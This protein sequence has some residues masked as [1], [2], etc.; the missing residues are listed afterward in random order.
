MTLSNQNVKK[1]NIK[2]GYQ[3]SS[4]SADGKKLLILY[5]NGQLLTMEEFHNKISQVNSIKIGA[6]LSSIV[7]IQK[8]PE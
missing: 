4:L 6:P 2:L 1:N 3:V 5:Y 7:G 8:N